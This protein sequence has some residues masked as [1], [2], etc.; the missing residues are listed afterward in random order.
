MKAE[1]N[2]W[3]ICG[4]SLYRNCILPLSFVSLCRATFRPANVLFSVYNSNGPLAEWWA[5]TNS[6]FVKCSS[7]SE[8]YYC[9]PVTWVRLLNIVSSLTGLFSSFVWMYMQVHYG[10]LNKFL[11]VVLVNNICWHKYMQ[12][13]WLKLNFDVAWI[14]QK[15]N[16]PYS[17]LLSVLLSFRDLVEI[18]GCDW[19]NQVR[20]CKV[21]DT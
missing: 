19:W 8:P 1:N 18:L 4:W 2:F 5:L 21:H 10:W 20:Q 6:L 15:V 12:L 11:L 7:F 16:Y 13:V 3:E 9:P 17:F 14:A